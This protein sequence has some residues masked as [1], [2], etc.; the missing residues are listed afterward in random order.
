MSAPARP[1]RQY[2]SPRRREQAVAT[3]RKI[4]ES[5][6]KL[7]EADGYEATSIA[8]IASTAGV[9]VKTVYLA[10][11][12]KSG[13]LIALWNFLLRGDEEPVPV[14]QRP[15]YR[16]VIEE[17]EPSQQ[18]RLNVWN[19]T[20]IRARIGPMLEVISGASV[21][22]PEVA[23]LWRRIQSEYYE[24]QQAIV[25]AIEQKGALRKGLDV[26]RA[27]DILWTLN[28]PVAY[29]LLVVERGWTPAEYEQ[30]LG[31]LLCRQ[32]LEPS[33]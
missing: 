30:W 8:A 2:D 6:Q 7:F 31:D 9:S 22:E 23:A 21:S 11:A 5:A 17:P 33:N 28:H 27:T 10:F 16:A 18:L 20:K 26:T 13:V 19:A 24:N 15:W 1:R 12:T 32:L 14:G 4:L 25:K 29:Q 3:R